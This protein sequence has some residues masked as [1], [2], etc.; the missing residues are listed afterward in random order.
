MVEKYSAGENIASHCTKCKL[1]LDHVVVAMNGE[2]IVKVQC[3]TCGSTHKFRNPADPPKVRVPRVKKESQKIDA[4]A[5]EWEAGLAGAKG[6]EHVYSMS[7]KYRI[8]DVVEHHS[9][10]KGIV[11]KL[12]MN[13]CDVL[14]KDKERLMA[15]AN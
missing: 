11:R 15:S 3:K 13:K 4:A 8:G 7:M 5:A 1:S 12:Y 9:F 14:F 2:S 6:K 10:G